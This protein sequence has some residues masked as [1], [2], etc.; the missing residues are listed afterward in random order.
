MLERLVKSS[1]FYLLRKLVQISYIFSDN[2][3]ILYIYFFRQ[4]TYIVYIFFS[5]NVRI[6]YIIFSDNVRILYIIF[7]DNVRILYIYFFRQCTFILY[8]YFPTMYEYHIYICMYQWCEFKSHRGKNK[9]LTAQKSNS[10]TVLFNFQTYICIY[11]RCI[12]RS[13][14]SVRVLMWLIRYI[15]Y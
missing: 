3:R 14:V 10:N 2:V 15:Y 8:I 1:R 9:K 13:E 5:D 7:S 11:I 4:C 6:L 12:I